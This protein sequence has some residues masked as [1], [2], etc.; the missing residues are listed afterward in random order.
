MRSTKTLP[1]KGD[2]PRSG[3]EIPVILT[4]LGQALCYLFSSSLAFA[5]TDLNSLPVCDLVFNNCHNL[6]PVSKEV[7]GC[8]LV[9]LFEQNATTI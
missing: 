2:I 5:A 4:L 3:F 8:L 1:M 7:F 9:D 6:P